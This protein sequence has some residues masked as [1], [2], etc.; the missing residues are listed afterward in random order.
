MER[1]DII[2]LGHVQPE[3][4]LG[5]EEQQTRMGHDIPTTSQRQNQ[6]DR[7]PPRLKSQTSE[8]LVSVADGSVK[9]SERRYVIN[10]LFISYSNRIVTTL[11]ISICT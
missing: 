11:K 7:K 8:S 2:S 9:S 10:I 4:C 1:K 3:E 5:L 6:Q